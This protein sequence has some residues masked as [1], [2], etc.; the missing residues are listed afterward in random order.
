V[1]FRA[2]KTPAE[3]KPPQVLW[4]FS[5]MDQTKLIIVLIVLLVAGGAYVGYST[6][7]SGGPVE[8][9]DHNV[10]GKSTGPGRNS[11]ISPEAK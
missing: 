2:E 7:P 10:P 1:R 4:R 3:W 6:A 11:L 5:A 9:T 8:A